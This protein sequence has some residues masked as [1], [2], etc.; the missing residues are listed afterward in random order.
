MQWYAG[1]PQR[2]HGKGFAEPILPFAVRF[3]C[4]A[5]NNPPVVIDL[6]CPYFSPAV[7][8]IF[9]NKYVPHV[10]IT[11]INMTHMFT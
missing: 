4:T 11:E 8:G 6:G 2:Q 1:S 5:K 9:L 7:P 10:H 3:G